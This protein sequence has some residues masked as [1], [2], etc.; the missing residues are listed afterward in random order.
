MYSSDQ[1]V[2]SSLTHLSRYFCSRSFFPGLA[3]KLLHRSMLSRFSQYLYNYSLTL[4]MWDTDSIQN[5][6]TQS[7]ENSF[8]NRITWL[9]LGLRGL[10]SAD[11]F[12]H[13][14]QLRL[15]GFFLKAHHWFLH[16]SFRY[17]WTCVS[18]L[19]GLVM[20]LV[21]SCTRWPMI[22]WHQLHV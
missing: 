10:G 13:F 9:H 8:I 20:R 21:I 17:Q 19:S 3:T 18:R 5:H 7:T 11:W 22:P 14:L 6:L 1:N 15:S 12:P 2:K 4:R 16:P